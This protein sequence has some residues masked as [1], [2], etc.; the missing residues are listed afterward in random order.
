MRKYLIAV[1]VLAA[2]ACGTKK[3]AAAADTTGMSA[4]AMTPD[5]TMK[6]TTKMG[7]DTGMMKSDTGKMK[8]DTGKGMKKP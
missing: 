5:T 2:A 6:D 1:A 7:S 4:P 8:G 3:Q